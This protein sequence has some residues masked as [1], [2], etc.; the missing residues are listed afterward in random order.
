MDSSKLEFLRGTLDVLILKALVWGPLHGYAITSLIRR[1]SD[2]AL[3]L[4]EGT[5]YPA[6][7]RLENKGLL[8][9]EWGLSEN[10]RKAKFYRLT[11]AGRRQ[12]QQE[13]KTWE[14]YA[15]AVAKVL[16]AANPPAAEE[17]G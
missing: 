8:A 17:A 3:L 12:L 2:E 4:E 11:S 16:G 10:N 9:S 7:W 1:Q 15:T 14:A 13:T 6:L 5:L